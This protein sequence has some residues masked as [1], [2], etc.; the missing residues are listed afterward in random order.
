MCVA[1]GPG[2]AEQ[3]SLKWEWFSKTGDPETWVKFV[4][5]LENPCPAGI[6]EVGLGNVGDPLIHE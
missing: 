6:R 2:A 5:G 4:A 1:G 3:D